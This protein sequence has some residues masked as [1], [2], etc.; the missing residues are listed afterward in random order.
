MVAALVDKMAELKV[1]KM[2]D[3]MAQLMASIK[4]AMW[5]AWMVEKSADSRAVN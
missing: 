3:L 2:G 5:A 4:V 1:E